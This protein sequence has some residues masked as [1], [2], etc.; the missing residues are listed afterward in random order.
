MAAPKVRDLSVEKMARGVCGSLATS[1]TE[2]VY[3]TN[4]EMGKEYYITPVFKKDVDFEMM[5][6]LKLLVSESE[7]FTA[8]TPDSKRL[9]TMLNAFEILSKRNFRYAKECLKIYRPLAKQC[10]STYERDSKEAADACVQKNLDPE[11][12][13]AFIKE[14]FLRAKK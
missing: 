8:T 3:N 13:S 9:S 14:F 7:K 12:T 6:Y 4:K 2:R 5:R 1:L 10:Y 11:E